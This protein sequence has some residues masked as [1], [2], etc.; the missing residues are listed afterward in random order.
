[1]PLPYIMINTITNYC[2]FRCFLAVFCFFTVYIF[3]YVRMQAD[4]TVPPT[5]IDIIYTLHVS[6]F[7]CHNH[8]L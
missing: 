3:I 1:M 2:V 8:I 4:A 7:M 5:C 6:F